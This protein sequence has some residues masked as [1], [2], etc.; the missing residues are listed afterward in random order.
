MRRHKAGEWIPIELLDAQGDTL[1]FNINRQY[2]GFEL[3][4]LLEVLLGFFARC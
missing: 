1:F 3:I 2:H 4:T